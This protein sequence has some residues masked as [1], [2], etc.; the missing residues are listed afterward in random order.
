VQVKQ[1]SSLSIVGN[2]LA[3]GWFDICYLL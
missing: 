3:T 1:L 2:D